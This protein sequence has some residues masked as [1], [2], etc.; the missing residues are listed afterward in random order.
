[1]EGSTRGRRAMRCAGGGILCS[2]RWRH[3][4]A[5]PRRRLALGTGVSLAPPS[6]RCG[7]RSSGSP[8]HHPRGPARR[9]RRL[10]AKRGR[11]RSPRLFASTQSHGT[12]PR[13]QA[14]TYLLEPG[15]SGTS[16]SRHCRPAGESS[17]TSPCPKVSH[18]RHRP[19]LWHAASERVESLWTAARDSGRDDVWVCHPRSRRLSIPRYLSLHVRHLRS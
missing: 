6:G 16:S 2:M 9:R 13:H 11:T 4:R 14:G 3:S 19:A 8:R 18:S 1:M 7:T 12:G 15:L 5:E 10:A 17:R